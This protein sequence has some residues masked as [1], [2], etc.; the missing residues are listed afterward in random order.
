MPLPAEHFEA[1]SRAK[2]GDTIVFANNLMIMRTVVLDVVNEDGYLLVL[3]QLSAELTHVPFLDDGVPVAWKV[4]LVDTFV[5][6]PNKEKFPIC[7][8]EESGSCVDVVSI[9]T[10]CEE[11]R[12]VIAK[13]ISLYKQDGLALTSFR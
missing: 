7:V 3:S 5:S 9:S 8:S 12:M 2:V 10:A 13:L 4:D 1:L 6:L 11:Y